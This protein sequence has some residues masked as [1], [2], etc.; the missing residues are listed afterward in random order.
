MTV[1]NDESIQTA[2]LADCVTALINV[3]TQWTVLVDAVMSIESFTYTSLR[4]GVVMNMSFSPK[5]DFEASGT[6]KP[7]SKA[8]GRPRECFLYM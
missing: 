3:V 4:A 8:D 1:N 2:R 6:R 5:V 7:W